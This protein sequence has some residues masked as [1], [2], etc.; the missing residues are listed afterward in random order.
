MTILPMLIQRMHAVD[1][2]LQK[3]LVGS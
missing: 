1:Q 3:I 2:W